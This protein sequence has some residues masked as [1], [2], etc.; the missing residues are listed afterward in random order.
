M[1]KNQ[2]FKEKLDGKT[3]KELQQELDYSKK[4]LKERMKLIEDIFEETTFFEEYFTDYF[5]P[6]IDTK[7]AL[8]F[9][10]NVCKTLENYATYILNS[11]EVVKDNKANNIEY[12]FIAN[13]NYF[14]KKVKRENHIKEEYNN[15]NIEV[16]P[17]IKKDENYLKAKEQKIFSSD[18]EDGDLG[19]ILKDYKTFI[20]MAK[21]ERDG[22]EV[23]GARNYYLSRFIGETRLDMKLVKDSYK[24]T[25][26][27]KNI[28]N[29][30]G[31]HTI[32]DIDLSNPEILEI[33]MCM[34]AEEASEINDLLIVMWD[35]ENLIEKANLKERDLEILNYYRKGY[36]K[37]E[38]SE[39]TGVSRTAIFKKIQTIKKKLAKK[40]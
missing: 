10:N 4:N 18:Y 24:G 38:I 25:I 30:I 40:V 34:D 6:H 36:N 16:I 33:L 28:T 7:D 11:E 23:L 1:Y 2:I 3:V 17:F 35:F 15:C 14:N 9:D 5:N 20:E 32:D 39:I 29:S 13:E 37:R 19:K 21:D 27:F 22:I 31:N 12:K 26:Y 8:S